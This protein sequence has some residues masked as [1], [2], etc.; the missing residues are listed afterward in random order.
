[1][2]HAIGSSFGSEFADPAEI[3]V[4][5]RAA[6]PATNVP[7]VNVMRIAI[8]SVNCSLRLFFPHDRPPINSLVIFLRRLFVGKDQTIAFKSVRATLFCTHE[9]GSRARSG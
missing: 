2:I 4:M 5:V 7:P 6:I 3:T 8:A 1:M 9:V